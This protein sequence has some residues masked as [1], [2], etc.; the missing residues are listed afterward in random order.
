LAHRLHRIQTSESVLA[1]ASAV[2]T[3]LLGL[4]N[5][6]LDGTVKRLR[7]QW[8]G[9]LRTV[10]AADFRELHGEIGANDSATGDRWVRIA[11]ALAGGEYGELIEFLILQN[12]AVMAARGGAP[13][14]EIQ[15]GKL[16]VRFRDEHGSL[17]SREQLPSLW[18]F[19]YFLDSLRTVAAALRED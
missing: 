11:E 1:P 19:P 6:D 7:D 10:N 15:G 13:W 9:G 3:H 17:P 2:F 18:R 5:K 8:G 14:L 4:E 16:S 12:K